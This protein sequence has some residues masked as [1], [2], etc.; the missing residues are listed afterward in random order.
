MTTLQQLEQPV[1]VMSSIL[2]NTIEGAY[3]LS[4]PKNMLCL[5][6]SF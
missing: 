5:G 2:S 1:Q 3:S 4:G 6:V